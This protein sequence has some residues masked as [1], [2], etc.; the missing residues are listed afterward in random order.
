MPDRRK[1]MSNDELAAAVGRMIEDAQS[2]RDEQ[3]MPPR[4]TAMEYYNGE[5]KDT[6]AEDNRSS[7][8]SKDVRAAIK[9]L[10]PSIYRTILGSDKVVEYQPVG[11][12]DE[13][14]AEQA[15]D[16]VNFIVIPEC[17]ARK[18]IKDAIHDALLLRNGILKWWFEEKT[19]I[20]VTRHSGLSDSE[21]T[22]LAA[23]DEVEVL[24]HSE[25][26]EQ[27]QIPETGELAT[28][29]LH[30]AKIKRT[31]AE[32]KIKLGTVPMEEFLIDEG[33]ASIEDAIIVGQQTRERRTDLI[34]AGYDKKVIMNLPDASDDDE[35]DVEELTRRDD[36]GDQNETDNLPKELREVDHYE[37]FV[38]IDHDQDGIAE[39]R[40]IV[41]I[42]GKKGK[43]IF[44]ND[45]WDMAPYSDV[46]MEDRPHQWEG[47]SVYDDVE[48]IQ[49]VKT[50][51]T[52]ETLDNI[53]WQNAQQ[54][55]Y[56]EGTVENPESVTTPRFGE[57]IRIR[58]GVSARD[59]VAYNSVPFVGESSFAMLGY[60]DETI[61]D[62]TGISEAA[63]G[64]APD[65][66]QN[67]TAKATGL[68]EQAGIGQVQDIVATIAD[69][70]LKRAF[71][72]LLKLVIQHQDKPRT[73]R[74]RDEWV[75]FDPKSWDASMDAT[76][77]TGLG[78][79]TRE[80]DMA[81]MTFIT[82]LQEKLL[83]TLGADNPFVKP[84]D[85]WNGISKMV[86]ATGLRTPEM[87]F[88]KPDEQEIAARLEEQR[89][90]PSPEEI[91]IQGQMQLEQAKL[92][93][94]MQLEQAKMASQANKEKAQMEA[95]LVVKTKEAENQALI[96]A[97]EIQ[98]KRDELATRAAIEERKLQQQ[99]E[100]E[101]LKLKVTEDSDGQFVPQ[102][103]ADI[104]E[105]LNLVTS[106]SAAMQSERRVVRDENGDII[107][108]SIGGVEQAIIRDGNDDI[109]GI[110]TL[111]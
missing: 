15:T 73:V 21:W 36:I 78:A 17:N 100:L 86:E 20:I 106:L 74:L 28:V 39:L 3:L 37:V 80:R 81:A 84:D 58:Q 59:A 60:M 68:I 66:L 67:M 32:G 85:L 38:R 65:A 92:Q 96:N 5:M 69:G 7:V 24:E 51:L 54:P 34:A 56:Q 70:G 27:V 52:R 61:T 50:V 101:L 42:G 72:G 35:Q 30:D 18:A 29:T 19:D 48:E 103:E 47:Y 22:Q 64:L 93:Q 87:Y 97:Q 105:L 95:D 9:K 89:N 82:Q 31:E 41:F 33:A 79:G 76:V 104:G 108:V 53:Y 43:N 62:R 26:Q 45:E 2:Y 55:V 88:T 90:T 12:G 44:D 46:R 94:Q 16:Y 91:K 6:P 98:F 25:R 75:T 110:G 99:R 107:G 11:E 71:S 23:P 14:S 1:P 8:V 83:T 111:N 49:R 4:L 63:S 13:E 77:N 40:R 102:R 10:K 109:I 57:P